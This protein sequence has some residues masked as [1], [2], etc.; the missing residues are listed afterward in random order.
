MQEHEPIYYIPRRAEV[1]WTDEGIAR[2]LDDIMEH[3]DEA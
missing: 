1:Q 2:L 3:G